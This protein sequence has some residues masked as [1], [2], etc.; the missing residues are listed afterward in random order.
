VPGTKRSASS[1]GGEAYSNRTKGLARALL[2]E[3]VAD[4]VGWFLELRTP[5]GVPL[6]GPFPICAREGTPAGEVPMAAEFQS[7]LAA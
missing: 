7:G 4:S 5:G 6:I 3:S 1:V 2:A